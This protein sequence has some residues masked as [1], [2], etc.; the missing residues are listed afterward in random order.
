MERLSLEYGRKASKLQFVVHPAP[1]TS[2]S[3]VEPYNSILTTHTNI[4]KSDCA[5]IVDNEAL[6]DICRRN[7]CVERPT[8]SNLNRLIS[9]IVSSVTASLRFEGQLNVDLAEFQTNLVPFPRVHFPLVSYA[10]LFSSERA[11]HEQFSVREITSACF[12]RG[13]Q[14]LKCDQEAGKYMA[15]CLLY[16]GD[17]VPKVCSYLSRFSIFRVR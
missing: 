10:P 6:Y 15:C 2:T 8:Y 14:M 4:D 17:V 7:L 1:Q 11:H 9:Q 13:N 3:V 16:R 12:D 5:F